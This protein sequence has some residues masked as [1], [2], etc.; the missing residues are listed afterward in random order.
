MQNILFLGEF[1]KDFEF[2]A[3]CAI[4]VVIWNNAECCAKVVAAN[5]PIIRKNPKK[6]L[7]A[8]TL[9]PLPTSIEINRFWRDIMQY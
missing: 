8:K 6:T 3:E 7:C 4:L 9:V 1:R 2:L 5:M